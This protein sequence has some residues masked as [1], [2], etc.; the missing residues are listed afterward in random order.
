MTAR[1]DE[2]SN[3]IGM[4]NVIERL[5]L[6]YKE[7]GLAEIESEPGKGTSVILKLPYKEGDHND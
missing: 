6:F 3:G 5:E 2:G 1:K 4:A 7:R